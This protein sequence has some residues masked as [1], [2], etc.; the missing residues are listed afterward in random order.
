MR[1]IVTQWIIVLAVLVSFL[2]QVIAASAS[3]PCESLADIHLSIA[4]KETEN[5]DDSECCDNECCDVD[6]PCATGACSSAVYLSN[7]MPRDLLHA[8]GGHLFSKLLSRPISF[9]SLVFRPPIFTS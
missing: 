9:I 3:V 6:C 4:D 7:E 8:F 1:K 2:G 5:H